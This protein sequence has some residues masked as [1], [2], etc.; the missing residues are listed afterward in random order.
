MPPSDTGVPADF[1][2]TIDAGVRRPRP[3]VLVGGSPVRLMR[4]S[5]AGAVLIDGWQQGHP[6]S[7][8]HNARRLARRLTDAGMAHPRPPANAPGN[9]FAL[10]PTAQDVTVII[11]V[12]D[13]PEGLRTTLDA[14]EKTGGLIVVDDGSREAEKYQ[15]R[16][17]V[18][19]HG[20][21]VV[22]REHTGGPAAARND[23]SRQ[24]TTAF[25]AFVDADCTPDR[26]WLDALLPH[27]DDRVIGAVAPRVR[28]RVANGP[29]HTYERKHSP[30][31]MGD[32]PGPVRPRSWVSYV[33]TAA[34]VVRREAF[35]EVGGFDET[36]RFGEDVD[37]V[38]RLHRLGWRVRYEPAGIV[39]HPARTSVHD[40]VRQRFDYGRSAAALAVRHG[41]AVTPLDISPWSLLPWLLALKGHV[42][43]GVAAAAGTAAALPVKVKV[44]D[45]PTA[46]TLAGLA[47][48]GNLAAGANLA[49]A[50]RRAWLL[51]LALAAT[52]ST[53]AR[54]ALLASTATNPLALADDVAYQAGVWAGVLAARDKRALKALLPR[55]QLGPGSATGPPGA[56]SSPPAPGT[57][58]R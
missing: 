56:R 26:G 9:P 19:A 12:R 18:E 4:L 38:W 39:E 13:R 22:R 50:V 52:R 8:K 51:P 58:A 45:W 21:D 1:G 37:F 48:K 10:K 42:K 40:W 25:V 2:L 29:M 5:P 7:T 11:P 24:A 28:A 33:P 47:W 17:H 49:R 44:S 53:T 35:D 14:L 54:R 31:D 16:K 3:D 46:K 36:L 23:G 55:F 41:D 57:P 32:R 30:L 15:Q 43:L 27:F 34:L 6:V 20:A